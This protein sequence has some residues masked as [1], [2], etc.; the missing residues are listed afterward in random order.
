MSLFPPMYAGAQVPRLLSGA[1]GGQSGLVLVSPLVQSQC[2]TVR[3]LKHSVAP[4]V[5]CRLRVSN[6]IIF[7]VVKLTVFYGPYEIHLQ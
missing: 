6:S 4:M 1:S 3:S 5:L 7:S 2:G